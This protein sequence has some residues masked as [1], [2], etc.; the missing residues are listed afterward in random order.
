MIDCPPLPVLQEAVDTLY[1]RLTAG[2]VR[3]AGTAITTG[4]TG[5]V[6]DLTPAEVAILEDVM[7]GRFGARLLDIWI[8]DDLHVAGASE[9][10]WALESEIAWCAIGHGFTGEPLHLIVERIMRAG[11]YRRK[12]DERRGAVTWL[13]Q[14]VANAIATTQKRR[15]E[16]DSGPRILFDDD[17][18]DDEQSGEP[19][20]QTV[21]RLRRELA[22]ERAVKAVQ[23]TVIR[24]ERIE[25][26]RTAALL[27]ECQSR[28]L[29]TARLLRN[30]DLKP[31]EKLVAIMLAW[32]VESARSRGEGES[33]AFYPAIAEAVGMS[34][35]TV[36]R[37]LDSLSDQP[38]APLVKRTVTEWREVHDEQSGATIQRPTS[39][40]YIRPRTDGSVLSAVAAYR[41]E[42]HPK[43]GGKRLPRCPEHPKADII[44]RTSTHCAECRR[45]LGHS[46]ESLR[47]QLANVED[48]ATPTVLD[49]TLDQQV[50][51]V[52]LDQQVAVVAAGGPPSEIVAP[53]NTTDRRASVIA[54]DPDAP[55]VVAVDVG[56]PDDPDP[57]PPDLLRA[58]AQ[59]AYWAR[60]KPWRCD[61]RLDGGTTC[62]SL[63]RYPR[64]GGGWRCDG[65]GQ[66]TVPAVMGAS[67]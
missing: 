24:G 41:P 56:L 62:T 8:R 1:A 23:Q 46:T 67:E 19:L 36:G 43:Q 61:R 13:A 10:D 40:V 31:P 60:P 18:A 28:A 39:A 9:D 17:T 42:N 22:V 29:E 45:P 50:A 33:R 14:D 15:A 51:N 54:L 12:H 27:K 2:R 63:E 47:Q 52:G 38:D 26:E 25:R 66:V 49:V 48:I 35:A 21:V 16:Y 4:L 32:Q 59:R 65:C 3:V 64:Q 58:P 5:Q 37:V 57:R 55:R 20:E 44:I 6:T 30:P 7:G 11:P 53:V 34:S